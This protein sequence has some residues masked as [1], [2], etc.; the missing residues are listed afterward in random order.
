MYGQEWK[1]SLNIFAIIVSFGELAR[2]LRPGLYVTID[3]MVL[4][5][6]LIVLS[7]D[8]VA[9][10]SEQTPFTSEIVGSSL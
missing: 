7:Y 3:L 10:S 8:V 6:D 5:Y 1:R 4:W 9:Q 2:N